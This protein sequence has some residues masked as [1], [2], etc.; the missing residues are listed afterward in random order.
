VGYPTFDEFGRLAQ[1]LFL[2][3][4]GSGFECAD[5]LGLCFDEVELAMDLVRDQDD[6]DGMWPQR[7]YFITMSGGL[8]RI[9][10]Y[11]RYLS[12]VA[13]KIERFCY[14]HCSALYRRSGVL[15]CV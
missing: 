5:C 10:P 8:L 7:L 14:F 1:L 12:M 15:Y 2:V 6:P 11:R 9:Q 13:H 3:W 4:S